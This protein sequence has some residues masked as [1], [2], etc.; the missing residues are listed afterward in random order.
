MPVQKASIIHW[1][2]RDLRIADNTALSAATKSGLPVVPVYLLSDWRNV[3]CWTGPNRQHFLCESLESLAKNLET[4]EGRLIIRQ[5]PA[6]SALRKLITESHAVALHFN[7]DPDPFGKSVE[8]AV[9][10][11]CAELG[12]EC[13]CHAD[14][15]LHTPGEVLTQSEMPYRVY[16]PYS[17][18]W[19]NLP[20]PSPLAKPSSLRTPAGL[21]SLPLPTVQ[22]WGLPTPVSQMVAAGERAARDRLKSAITGKIQAY[23]AKR[24]FPAAEGTSRISQDLRHGTLSI[25]TVYAECLAAEASADATGKAGIAIFIKELAWRE[26]YFA[27][28]HHFPNVLDAEF[29]ADW[30]GLPWDEPG[31]RFELWKQGRTGFPIVDAGMRELTATGFMHNRV[32]MITAMFLTKDLHIDWKLGESWFMQNLVDGEIASNNG[33]WQWS[34]GTGADA[35]PYFRIQNP[36]A[37]TLKFDAAGHYIRK[38]VPELAKTHASRFLEAPKDGRPI[39]ADYPLP[40]VDHKTERDRTLAIFKKHR[41]GKR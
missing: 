30:R 35:A 29:N 4:L 19:L 21:H 25:R 22:V 10:Q 31:E 7:A 1:F 38:W 39:A 13:H 41:E 6:V 5:G 32:R 23:S 40:C 26:F 28:L 33:G 2:R 14:A 34:A 16:T 12:I 17:R 11:L 20:K 15:A 18:N 8:K 3:H 9:F 27:I 37:Q 36:W 24:D